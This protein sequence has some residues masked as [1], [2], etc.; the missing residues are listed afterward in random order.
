[1]IANMSNKRNKAEGNVDRIVRGRFFPDHITGRVFVDVGAAGPEYLSISALYRSIGWRVIALEPNPVF[2]EAHRAKGH[3]VYPYACGD[4]DE[5]NIDF[6]VVNSHGTKYRDGQVSYESF[7]S[8]AIKES[9]SSLK[10]DLDTRT[11]KVNLRRLDTILRDHAPDIDHID[12]LSADVEGWELE[13]LD[14]LDMHKYKPR[15]MIIENLFQDEKYRSYMKDINYVLW[16]RISPND[17][18]VDREFVTS[19]AR[20]WRRYF[21]DLSTCLR[22]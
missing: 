21:Y 22:R 17:I 18:Y 1:M 2:Y 13:V 6:V 15:V 20:T 14:G 7:S 19:G 9:Y 16:R 8:I 11:I 4:R 3:E 12:I 10:A 5:D